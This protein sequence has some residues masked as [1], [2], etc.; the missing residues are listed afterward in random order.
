M[1]SSFLSVI[2]VALATLVMVGNVNA[3]TPAPAAKP[4]EAPKVKKFTN[5]D[6]ILLKQNDFGDQQIADAINAAGDNK[7]FDT[8]GPGLVALKTS[9]ISPAIIDMVFGKPYVAP[10]AP[11]VVAAPVVE[12]PPAPVASVGEPTVVEKKGFWRSVVGVVGIGKEDKGNKA[13]EGSAKGKQVTDQPATFQVNVPA[14]MAFT[15]VRSKLQSDGWM[16]AANTSRDAGQIV[17]EKTKDGMITWKQVVVNLTPETGGK[18]TTVT[19]SYFK[20]RNSVMANRSDAKET[21]VN[22]IN[23]EETAKLAQQLQTALGPTTQ[24][25]K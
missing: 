24:A 22:K 8:S 21:A 7:L 5:E 23:P 9:G 13:V 16:L 10:P 19:V 15:T 12:P 4:V 18:T 6:V 25:T 14:D 2:V 17:T 11:A 20:A 3:Q 1:K